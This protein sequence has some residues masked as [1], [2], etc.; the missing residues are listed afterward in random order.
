[1]SERMNGR[2]NGRTIEL[3]MQL[4]E[5]LLQLPSCELYG[6][7]N[8]KNKAILLTREKVI[9]R[10]VIK[11]KMGELLNKLKIPNNDRWETDDNLYYEK[12]K[13]QLR[14]CKEL[15]EEELR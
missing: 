4:R 2:Q 13:A 6:I 7:M 12:I 3:A 5:E 14:L 11:E 10:D 9:R 1:M 8:Y 15:L